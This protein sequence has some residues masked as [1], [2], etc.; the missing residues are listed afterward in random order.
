MTF[1]TRKVSLGDRSYD[2]FFDHNV[3]PAVRKWIDK[4]HFGKS[5]YVVTD[6]NVASI[7]GDDIRRWLV[8]EPEKLLALP[9]GEE[10]KTLSAVGRIYAFLSE[11]NADRDS[12]VV[13]FGGGVVGDLAGFAA[14]TFLRGISFIQIPTT[15]LSMLDSS[16]GGKTG[17]N[18]PEGKNL[19]GAFHQPCAVFIDDSFLDTLD[20]RN[21]HSGLAEAI[22]CALAGDADLW[23]L[24]VERGDRWKAF[25]GDDWREII[26]RSVSFK[27]SVVERDE[28][29]SHLRKILNLGH[30][31][32]HAL[33]QSGGYGRLLHGEAVAAGLAWEAVL[34][35]RMGV[36]PESVT[37]DVLSLLLG[38]GYGLDVP[39][40]PLA[41]IE[42]AVG[43]D[44][45]RVV[46]DMDLPLIVRPGECEIR[47][48]PLK[49]IR[50]ELAAVRE[51]IQS[52]A[53]E[54]ESD[55]RVSYFGEPHEAVRILEGYV[56][57]NPG[58][59]RAIMLLAEARLRS[60][61]VT[62]ARGAIHEALEKNISDPSI[63]HKAAQ[64]EKQLTLE[65]AST[66]ESAQETLSS[67]NLPVADAPVPEAAATVPEIDASASFSDSVLSIETS[68]IPF[69]ETP[70]EPEAQEEPKEK[71]A[72]EKGDLSL[73][74]AFSSVGTMTLADLYWSQG[75]WSAAR[76]I[77]KQILEDD[78]GNMRAKKWMDLHGEED[79]VES[80]LEV[81]LD[82][83]A[84]EFGYDLS[85]Y[86]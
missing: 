55:R 47:R 50:K 25:S 18:L 62:A 42:A 80:A 24:F 74:E 71:I 21:L 39:D 36:T 86:H 6:R 75:E 69:V 44:K 60:G 45:K 83:T 13:A 68:L 10:H 1:E 76:K 11:G 38:M 77:V 66:G 35:R 49:E 12:I 58:D 26:H 2:I 56:A 78:P 52:R 63:L 22:K 59:G 33:E 67:D 48:V 19:A 41:S 37:D 79:P 30:T 57:A 31:I 40:I 23:K 32:G 28:R 8:K 5:V 53:A 72:E 81:F 34:G 3:C 46:S 84:K 29:E 43:M 82:L 15:L 7:Y 51:E 14:A 64:L 61:N 9:P 16:V 54:N 85:R 65:G 73:I 70:E 17:F 27:I 20:D 4:Y